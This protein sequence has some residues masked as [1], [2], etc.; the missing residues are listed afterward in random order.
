MIPST[1]VSPELENTAKPSLSEWS[2]SSRMDRHEALP[3]IAVDG[4][5]YATDAPKPVASASA[6][7]VGL[8]ETGFANAT[9]N[10]MSYNVRLFEIAH[11]NISAA[12]DHFQEIFAVQS[13]P[14]LI[15]RSTA[16]M[17]KQIELFSAQTQDLLG[18]GRK[19]FAETAKTIKPDVK[20]FD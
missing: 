8:F 5:T 17:R 10:V 14:E 3:E 9:K 2:D 20:E 11:A 19:A 1:A 12:V 4:V 13:L 16:N 7:A 6:P 18:L 15:E